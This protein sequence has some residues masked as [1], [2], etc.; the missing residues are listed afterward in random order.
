[1]TRAGPA[2][3]HSGKQQIDD[4]WGCGYRNI[5]MQVS[6]QLMRGDPAVKQALFGGCGFVPDVGEFSKSTNF[7]VDAT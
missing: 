7:R 1:M 2:G 3:F 5:Q 6:H 4:G